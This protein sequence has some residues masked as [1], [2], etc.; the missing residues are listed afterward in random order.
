MCV[1][2]FDIFLRNSYTYRKLINGKM[3]V[4]FTVVLVGVDGLVL[5]SHGKTEFF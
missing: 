2:G 3:R 4:L 5:N 1:Y